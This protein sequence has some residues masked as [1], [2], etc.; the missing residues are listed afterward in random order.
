M[1]VI[2]LI[3]SIF[4]G[5]AFH[6]GSPGLFIPNLLKFH[7]DV[8]WRVWCHQKA[9]LPRVGQSGPEEALASPHSIS[10]P[11]HPGSNASL[12]HKEQEWNVSVVSCD[13][14]IRGLDQG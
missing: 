4:C 11:L 6:F 14:G 8:A 13:G 12:Q 3:L 7:D 9:C 1:L 5:L 10:H 2:L